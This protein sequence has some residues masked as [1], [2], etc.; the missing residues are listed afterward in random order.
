MGNKLFGID[1]AGIV[2]DT[3]SPGL[4]DLTLTVTT[5]G[6]RTPGDLSGGTNPT[7]VVSTGKG[8]KEPLTSIRPESI[9]Q[10][11]MA[12]ILII[13]DSLSPA[14]VPEEQDL[15]SIEGP[16]YTIIRVARDPAAA[17]YTCQVKN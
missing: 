17:T 2:N 11:A 1:I 8:I 13:G 3:I 9:V 7:T 12:V 5:P 6:T 4:L 16:D 15:V 14:A 10:D